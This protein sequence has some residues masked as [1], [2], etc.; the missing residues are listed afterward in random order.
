MKGNT[1]LR[2]ESIKRVL[3]EIREKGPISKRELQAITGFSWGNISSV[4]N[5]LIEAG[6]IEALGK[7]ETSIGRK[8]E[9][10]D[11]NTK[12]NYI[13]GID[14]NSQGTLV[15]VCDLKGRI[16]KKYD[17]KIKNNDKDTALD[18]LYSLIET[19]IGEN[20]H[21]NIVSISIAMQGIV[22]IQ[23]GVSVRNNT[24]NGW[25]NVNIAELLHNKFSKKVLLFHDPDCILYAERYFG[26]LSGEA[27]ENALL[28]RVDHGTGIAAML[29]G[30]IYMGTKNST[31]EIGPSIV[32]YKNTVKTL[33][34]IINYRGIEEAYNEL[35][36]KNLNF[37]E[38]LAL[39]TEN[40]KEAYGIISHAARSFG[41]ALH[42]AY[43][44]FNP[45]KIIV[46]GSEKQYCNLLLNQT[47]KEL[48]TVGSK[49][50]PPVVSEL[51]Y[52]AA[53]IGAALFAADRLIGE[54]EFD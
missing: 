36:N 44:L 49:T 15:A 7:Q 9:E 29:S 39:A 47:V 48:E 28:V 26:H 53:A 31:C 32:P 33:D 11:I 1:R 23:N 25:E 35:T 40:N 17:S 18:T 43:N 6:Y 34:N 8:P 12:D 2:Q 52:E 4:T 10:V 45:E 42:N 16:V 54:L 37:K 38:V 30:R 3:C 5:L 22:D 19:A 13:I 41:F 27:I 24:I 50:V 46:F 51:S 21:K 14:F 20:K